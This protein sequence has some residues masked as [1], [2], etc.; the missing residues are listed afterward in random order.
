MNFLSISLNDRVKAVSV[1]FD[2]VYVKIVIDS[3]SA[4]LN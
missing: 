3:Y 4:K 2:I 1:D